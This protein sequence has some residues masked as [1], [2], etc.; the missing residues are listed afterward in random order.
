MELA[1]NMD[2]NTK[3]FDKGVTM[4]EIVLYLAITAIIS[5]A[6]YSVLDL[7]NQSKV[8]NQITS[9]VEY[10]GQII[11]DKVL[12]SIRDSKKV[13]SPLFQTSDTTLSLNTY[14][15]MADPT[16]FAFSGG[17]LTIKEGITGSLVLLNNSNVVLSGLSFSNNTV[18]S[19]YDSIRFTYTISYNNQTGRSF[20]DYSKTF[21]GTA[22]TRLKK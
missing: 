4:I 19:S 16:V 21:Y 22:S 17:N 8:R 11:M 2:K 9:E 1:N 20:Y 6:S 13:N 14:S 7:I 5:F 15:A 12:Q 18:S 3:K 10:Q